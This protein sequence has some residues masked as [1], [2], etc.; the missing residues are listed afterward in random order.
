MVN[1]IKEGGSDDLRLQVT[2]P[3]RAAGLVEENTN[4]GVV[5]L[6]S[7]CVYGFDGLLL[8]IDQSVD[9]GH[10]A[11]LVATAANDTGSV[12]GGYPVTVAEA[13]N[14]YQLNLPGGSEAGFRAGDKAPVVSCD[15]V[16]IIH[17]VDSRRLAEDLAAVRTEQVSR[18]D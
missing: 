5:R 3:A 17:S 13:G 4:G 10:R 12:H 11:G 8:V 9:V 1:A 15:S 14:G 2:A 18:N 7:V 6:A 16:I